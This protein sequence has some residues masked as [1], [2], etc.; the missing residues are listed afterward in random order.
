MN[1]RTPREN[2]KSYSYI[3][4]I[5]V[6]FLIVVTL[7]SNFM[8]ELSKPLSQAFANNGL[9]G[10]LMFN[11]TAAVTALLNLWYFWL[12]RRAADGK[13]KGTFYMILLLLGVISSLITF[14]TTSGVGKVLSLDAIID[15]CGLYFLLQV[16]KEGK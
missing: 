6:V 16:M 14:F 13:S 1:K 5:V 2:L 11:V 9:D 8:P 12:A 15:I 4:I 10:M 3:Y 7:I